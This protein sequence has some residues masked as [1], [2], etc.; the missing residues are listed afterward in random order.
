MPD[1]PC[2]RLALLSALVAT[3]SLQASENGQTPPAMEE[4]LITA[5][6]ESRTSKGATGLPLDPRETPQSIS[7]V[8]YQQMQNFGADSLNEALRLA[9][10]ISVEEWETNRTNYVARGFEIKSTQIDGVGLPNNWGLVV[11]A[12]DSFGFDKIE[13]IRGA[14]GLLT[15]VGSAAGTINYVRKRPTNQREGS[16]SMTAGSEDL[17]RLEAD[18]SAPLT[19]DGQW[20]ARVVVATEDR[21]SHIRDL[22]NDR[23]FLYGVIDGQLGARSTLTA[24]YSYQVS[25]TDSNM[26]GALVLGYSDGSQASFR[27]SASTSQDWAWW[28]TENHNAFAEYAVA[29]APGWEL[30]L[31]YNY[32]L[33]EDDGKLF[34]VFP[35]ATS[36]FDPVT[37]LGL[38]GN[39]G[40]YPTRD[41]AHLFDLALTGAFSAF[42]RKHEVAA[43][44]SYAEGRRKL[45]MRPV[46]GTDPAWGPLPAFPYGGDVVPEPA[47]GDRTHY[48]LTNIELTRVYGATRLKP[49]DRVAVVL[50]VNAIEFRRDGDLFSDPF[51]QSEREISPYA[52]VTVDI[53]DAVLVYA[54]YSDIYQPQDYYD[55]NQEYLA[56]TKGVNYEA[57]V[58]AGWLDDQLL[59][60]L[61]LFSAEQEGLG[62]FVG[63]NPA[64]NN[65]YYT[66]VDIRSEGVE[67]ELSGRIGDHVEVLIG[68]TWLQLEDE[69]GD[70]TYEWVPRRTVNFAISSRLPVNPDISIGLSGRWQSD[71]A[72]LDGYSNV[73]IR[74][75]S[76]LLVNGFARWDFS[77]NA[78]VLLNVNNLTNEKY[79]TSLYEVGYYAAPLNGSVTVGYRF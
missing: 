54:S 44:V 53:T 35:E 76:Y 11:G 65:Y 14:N 41:D 63:L 33:F 22:E 74:Q 46:S 34:F 3:S 60:T 69:Q 37:R 70:D 2:L 77:D 78:Y 10:G 79:L 45:H 29:L 72:K 71:T 30:K 15:G 25:H 43:G 52:G 50:G 59:T 67:L 39:P 27:R 66:G 17:V 20:A 31:S 57:G 13:V 61:A 21:G 19:D 7:I 28:D 40:S 42:G 16:V 49:H 48:S 64:T 12:I 8:D 38:M 23:T 56:P 58:K 6:R 51:S 5:V 36:G 26:W 18:Y 32:R 24:G 73:E 55:I 9:T 4:L 47:W 62:T 68:A 75:R 1:A